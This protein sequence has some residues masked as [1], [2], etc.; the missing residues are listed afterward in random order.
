[1]KYSKQFAI[2][3]PFIFWSV[4]IIWELF[5]LKFHVQLDYNYYH[6]K[7]NSYFMAC[8]TLVL[9]MTKLSILLITYNPLNYVVELRIWS[10][11]IFS[12][13]FLVSGLAILVWSAL[14][15]DTALAMSAFWTFGIVLILSIHIGIGIVRKRE[16]HS[17]QH[18][19]KRNGG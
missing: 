12:I 9:I 14:I 3:M 18:G 16:K 7:F 13:L 6:P 1:M 15:R 2:Y 19:L 8:V 10:N 17:T 4:Y 5:H 11:I